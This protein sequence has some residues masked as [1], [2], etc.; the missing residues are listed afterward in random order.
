[1]AKT[2]VKTS[3]N[4]KQGKVKKSIGG[5]L[6]KTLIPMI[7]AGIVLIIVILVTQGRNAIQEIALLDLKSEGRANALELGTSFRMLTA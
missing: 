5:T 7:V 3:V 6:L 1:M 4:L 2:T